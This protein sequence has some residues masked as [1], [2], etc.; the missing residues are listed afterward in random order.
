MASIL[1]A[2]CRCTYSIW[3]IALRLAPQGG[4]QE[5][6][7]DTRHPTMRTEAAPTDN[8]RALGSGRGDNMGRLSPILPELLGLL[9]ADELII[10]G[11]QLQGGRR[12]PRRVRWLALPHVPQ[13]V[14]ISA[15]KTMLRGELITD[16]ADQS[17]RGNFGTRRCGLLVMWLYSVD[18]PCAALLQGCPT[19]DDECLTHQRQPAVHREQ[20]L[21]RVR[22]IHYNP[23]CELRALSPRVQVRPELPAARGE[24]QSTDGHTRT[25]ARD[26]I[27][28]QLKVGRTS[29][30]PRCRSNT[31]LD[32]RH[33]P[34][35]TTLDHH[36][37]TPSAGAEVSAHL[38][39]DCGECVAR[40]SGADEQHLRRC[41]NIGAVLPPIERHQAAI[42]RRHTLPAHEP[43]VALGQCVVEEKKRQKRKVGVPEPRRLFEGR[44]RW[45]LL[46]DLHVRVRRLE[47]EVDLL[48]R[49]DGIE[50]DEEQISQ[51]QQQ[52]SDDIRRG[53]MCGEAWDASGLSASQRDEDKERE[54]G[55]P[56]LQLDDGH[57]TDV[58]RWCSQPVKR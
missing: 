42:G 11:Q 49:R 24:A 28:G 17:T 48:R 47:P 33:S 26:V 14:S 23:R 30:R 37:A 40:E 27:H 15:R 29:D 3:S 20:R 2:T 45:T 32:I 51:Q 21:G 1:V 39:R 44:Q 38:P 13:C 10:Q 53:C 31:R 6:G 34:A 50:W 22:R 19:G 36:D 41:R 9:E 58:D 55:V 43:A 7:R 18:E 52:R 54:E 4:L 5:F 56:S 8:V 57:D 16:E 25:D 46:E 12:T 35:A